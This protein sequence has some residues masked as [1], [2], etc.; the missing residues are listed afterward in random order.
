MALARIRSGSRIRPEIDAWHKIDQL[1]GRFLE[2]TKPHD[3]SE[4]ETKESYCWITLLPL[5]HLAFAGGCTRRDT[6]I[7]HHGNSG[8]SSN[9]P[10]TNTSCQDIRKDED[11]CCSC[12][13]EESRTSFTD[14]V[15]DV[16][17]VQKNR[18]CQLACQ[19]SRLDETVRHVEKNTCTE[20]H[21]LTRSSAPTYPSPCGV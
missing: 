11:A 15:D 19:R 3:I 18:S 12:R 6:D 8:Q 5:V 21:T 1:I 13:S 9:S 10:D 17:A 7:G 2:T 14:E 20:Q 16:E 4:W